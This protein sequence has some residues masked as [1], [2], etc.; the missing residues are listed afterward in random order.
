PRCC[1]PKS[2]AGRR[3]TTDMLQSIVEW[4]IRN[5]VAVV[6]LAALLLVLGGYAAGHARLDVFPEFAPPQVVIQT[7]APGLSPTEVEKLV[8]L[9]IETAVNGIASLDL[10]RSQSIQG[11]SVITVIFQDGTDIFRAR[12][13]VA[14]RLAEL[15][16]PEGVKRARLGPLTATTGRLLT[17]GFSSVKLSAMQ[18]RDRVQWDVR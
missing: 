7:E 16:L 8:T 1:S 2:S 9:P 17:V 18:L 3:T 10:L 5:R 4:S 11:L 13:Q 14:E 15:D 6:V 12:Q